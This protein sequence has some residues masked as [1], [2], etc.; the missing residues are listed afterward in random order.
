MGTAVERYVPPPLRVTPQRDGAVVARGHVTDVQRWRDRQ[1][2]R[3][4]SSVIEFD[5]IDRPRRIVEVR[6]MPPARRAPSPVWA[7]ILVGVAL[8]LAALALL[9]DAVAHL[10]G[11]IGAV[12]PS[13]AGVAAVVAG[14]LWLASRSGGRCHITHWRG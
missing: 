9:V 14:V 1:V 12:L 10:V 6:M 7:L 13:L 8:V 4:P 2:A 5:V 11:A 3:H